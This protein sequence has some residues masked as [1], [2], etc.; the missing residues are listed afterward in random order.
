MSTREL[1]S[2]II[3][4]KQKTWKK[5]I[6]WILTILGWLILLAYVGYV[7]YGSLAIKYGW[8]LPENAL[9]NRE[10][11]GEAK[12]YYFIVFIVLLAGFVLFI[13]WKNYNKKRFGSLNRRKFRPEVTKEELVEKFAIDRLMVETLQNDRIITL[14]KNIIPEKM[15]MNK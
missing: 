7:I 9:F 6:E 5:I 13:I 14:E 15:G 10:M 12:K 1:D 8:F 11:L 3:V 4:G 2:H